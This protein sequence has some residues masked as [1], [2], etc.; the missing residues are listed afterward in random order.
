VTRYRVTAPYLAQVPTGEAAMRAAGIRTNGTVVACDFVQ[1][2][3]LPPDVPQETLDRLLAT[4]M[5][6]PLEE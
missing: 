3:V 2:S 5:I 1:G 4:G 6:E